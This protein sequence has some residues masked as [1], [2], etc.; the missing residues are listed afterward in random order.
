MSAVRKV[1][2]IP[3]D[4]DM[5]YE[6]SGLEGSFRQD[7]KF[8]TSRCRKRNTRRDSHSKQGFMN[9]KWEQ[10]QDLGSAG[11]NGPETRRGWRDQVKVPQ[12]CPQIPEVPTKG[13]EDPA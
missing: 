6:T 7:G 4:P 3:F 8:P 9:E 13:R 2:S 10:I 12:H 11:L 5:F 1:I